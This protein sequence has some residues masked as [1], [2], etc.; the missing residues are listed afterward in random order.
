MATKK[1]TTA[2][3]KADP[4][5]E[6]TQEA[7]EQPQVTTQIADL[8]DPRTGAPN[9]PTGVIGHQ[10]RDVIAQL[11]LLMHGAQVNSR[12]HADAWLAASNA[13]QLVQTRNL[14]PAVASFKAEVLCYL[15]SKIPPA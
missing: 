12:Q 9:P 2:E 10:S 11:R 3:T 4:Q 1:S 6:S 7:A 13:V 8:G 5:D 15:R 14:H